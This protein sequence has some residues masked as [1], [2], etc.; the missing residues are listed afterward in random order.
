MKMSERIRSVCPATNEMLDKIGDKSTLFSRAEEM[1]TCKFGAEG[2]CCRICAMGP[3]N[4]SGK[5]KDG[6][7][8]TGVCG[9]TAGTVAARNF[10]RQVAGGA[11][12]HADHGRGVAV[13]FLAAAKGE[14]SGYEIKDTEKL[15]LV[16]GYF[17]IPTEGKSVQEIAIAVAEAAL[18]EWGKQDSTPMAYTRR[19]P[20][21]R[22]EIWE[23]H[24]VMPRAF[25]RELVQLMHHTHAGTD[26]DAEHILMQ[27]VRAV[28]ADGWGGSMLATDL[29]DILFGTPKPVRSEANFGILEE[30][31]VNIM[32]HGHEPLLSEKIVDVATDPKMIEYA[33]SKGA[34]GITLGGV[35]CTGNEIMMRRGV[36]SAGNVLQQELVIGTGV[37]DAMIVDVQCVFQSIVEF[38]KDYHTKIITTNERAHITGA[39]R[40]PFEEHHA[41]ENARE[42]V[43]AAIDNFANRKGEVFIP[44]HKS[45]MI[46]GYSHEY[47]KYML[48]G[49][50]RASF[51]PLNDAIISGR[52]QGAAA[53]VGC[54]N[55]RTPHDEATQYLVEEFVKR[56]ILVVMTGC[57]AIGAGKLGYMKPEFMEKAG[58]GLREICETIGIAPVLH[59][60]SCVDN[61]R[62]LTILA[63]IVNEGGLGEDISDLPAVGLAPE[64][65]SEKAL[66]IG[67]YCVASGAHVVFGGVQAPYR[68]SEDMMRLMTEGLTEK[69]GAGFEFFPTKEEILEASLQKIQEKRKALGIDTKKERVLFDMEMRRELSV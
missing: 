2:V 36:A 21:K 43:K 29:Q 14:V 13:T 51:R 38:A 30:K 60:G 31:N 16:A 20:K 37:V 32:L 23:K 46:A 59:L 44:N 62:I 67:L 42:I 17:D 18:L 22:R 54:N 56:D 25:D 34:E 24:D 65:Y 52:I 41:D 69:F 68:G 55:P 10:A 35:C 57:Q 28:L 12:A 6:S 5:K 39:D 48:G 58:P 7:P 27:S 11:A 50:M 61:S 64:W 4:L 1:K 3:C 49:K 47:I 26:Q 8:K 19:A 63:E 45:S 66:D 33:K 40:I 9:A 15:M 53:I